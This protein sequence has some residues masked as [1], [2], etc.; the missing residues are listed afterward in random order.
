MRGSITFEQPKLFHQ[1][2]NVMLVSVAPE[3]PWML[4]WLLRVTIKWLGPTAPWVAGKAFRPSSAKAR[5]VAEGEGEGNAA[6]ERSI[7]EAL[8]RAELRVGTDF[9]RRGGGLGWTAFAAGSRLDGRAL[10]GIG[11]WLARSGSRKSLLALLGWG[12]GG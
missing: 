3:R 5:K 2:V 8:A 1:P 4:T 6:L 12:T 11:M 7:G 10:A 9:V